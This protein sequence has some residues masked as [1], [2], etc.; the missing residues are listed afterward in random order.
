MVT[1]LGRMVTY[2]EEFLTIKLFNASIMWSCKVNESHYI[3]TTRVHMATK[4]S[5]MIP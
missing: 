4:L 3:S 1:K 2:L 5:K